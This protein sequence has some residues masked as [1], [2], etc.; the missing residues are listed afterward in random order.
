VQNGIFLE[1]SLREQF[2]SINDL[3]R[4]ASVEE[5][6]RQRYGDLPRGAT[7]IQIFGKTG[8]ALLENLDTSISSRLW[9][10]SV[11]MGLVRP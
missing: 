2:Q 6:H 4:G 7:N 11:E 9:A 5:G 8:N 10:P 3:I 1:G